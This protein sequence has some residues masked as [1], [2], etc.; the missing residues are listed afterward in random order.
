MRS[1]VLDPGP[2]VG[3]FCPR[4]TRVD[5]KIGVQNWGSVSALSAVHFLKVSLEC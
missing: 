1:V 4:M 2:L 5:S 3:W